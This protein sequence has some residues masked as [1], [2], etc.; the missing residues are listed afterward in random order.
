M[1]TADLLYSVAISANNRITELL[2]SYPSYKPLTQS[3]YYAV[4]SIH[5]FGASQLPQ[6]A[7]FGIAGIQQTPGNNPPII[8]AELTPEGYIDS[9]QQQEKVKF[10]DA[11]P[12]LNIEQAD[13]LESSSILA[14]SGVE[15]S[16]QSQMVL[17]DISSNAQ[18]EL[19]RKA[20][21]LETPQSKP[22]QTLEL[23]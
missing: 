5:G 12:I 15:V 20:K 19:E 7:S 18:L 21:L 16:K 6:E 23:E 8:A 13:Q 17:S 1:K 22:N 4:K 11:S 14:H 10:Q 3:Q 2:T 9:P